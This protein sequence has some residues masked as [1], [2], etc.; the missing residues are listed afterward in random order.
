MT[1]YGVFLD[2]LIENLQEVA[3]IMLLPISHPLI[4]I[5][6]HVFSCV[7]VRLCEYQRDD[8]GCILCICIY[9]CTLACACVCKHLYGFAHVHISASM[10]S[11]LYLLGIII[12]GD[13]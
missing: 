3:P 10:Q 11:L 2:I 5:Y 7:C 13:A 12:A 1:I 6:E 9:V 8:S 4:V